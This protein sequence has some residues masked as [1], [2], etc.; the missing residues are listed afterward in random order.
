MHTKKAHATT[1]DN[2]R[3]ALVSLVSERSRD[4]EAAV[5]EAEISGLFENIEAARTAVEELW[6]VALDATLPAEKRAFMLE[7][8]RRAAHEWAHEAMFALRAAAHDAKRVVERTREG[9]LGTQPARRAAVW[10]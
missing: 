7:E 4:D 1:N 10:P 6:S 5:K 2:P 3:N 8:S 9:E